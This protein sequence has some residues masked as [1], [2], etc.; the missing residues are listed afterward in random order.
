MA[1]AS[2]TTIHRPQLLHTVATA[3]NRLL[4][5]Y[6]YCVSKRNLNVSGETAACWIAVWTDTGWDILSASLQDHI[7][8]MVQREALNRVDAEET[9]LMLDLREYIPNAA[10]YAQPSVTTLN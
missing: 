4:F 5:Y 6:G 3:I 10:Q 8:E 9:I 1:T 7:A 2:A